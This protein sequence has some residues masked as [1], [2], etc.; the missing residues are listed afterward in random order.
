MNK[1]INRITDNHIWSYFFSRN[2]E[3]NRKKMIKSKKILPLEHAI[4]WL[5]NKREIFYYN[6][7]KKNIIYFWQEIKKFNNKKYFIGGWHSNVKK[8]NLL[9]ILF[10]LKW[11]FSYNLK[12]KYK[13][14][15]IAVVKKNNKK[16]LSLCKYLGYIEIKNK[17]ERYYKLIKEI[18]NVNFSNY[19]YLILLP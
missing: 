7:G 12:K 6:I 15:W 8:V 1:K 9:Y 4:W 3:F 2:L 14:P 17:R 5:S 16:I 13:Y 10:I 19:F 11:Q 18:F